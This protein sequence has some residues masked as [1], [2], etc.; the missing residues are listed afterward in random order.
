MV[1]QKF[2]FEDKKNFWQIYTTASFF[3]IKVGA[4]RKSYEKLMRYYKDLNVLFQSR[5]DFK[6]DKL[7]I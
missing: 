1:F 3:L 4:F 6:F 7:I 5:I 2:P